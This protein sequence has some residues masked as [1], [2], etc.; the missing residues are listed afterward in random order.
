MEQP[1]KAFLLLSHVTPLTS[2]A[3]NPDLGSD[4]FKPLFQAIHYQNFLK[5]NHTSMPSL[6]LFLLRR[7]TM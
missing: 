7:I 3:I 2:L 1:D 6:P 5:E 4:S